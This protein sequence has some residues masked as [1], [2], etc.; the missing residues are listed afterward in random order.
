LDQE[1]QLEFSW[2]VKKKY[3]YKTLHI[4]QLSV[5]IYQEAEPAS[6]L[7]FCIL[8]QIEARVSLLPAYIAS[9]PKQSTISLPASFSFSR[10]IRSILSIR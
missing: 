6:Y 7:S 4:G 8:R 2:R 1:I 10:E 3:H 9:W 5:L